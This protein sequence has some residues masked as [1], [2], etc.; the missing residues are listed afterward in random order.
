MRQAGRKNLKLE[1]IDLK[2]GRKVQRCGKIKA[3][4]EDE[5]KWRRIVMTIS[6]NHLVP[7]FT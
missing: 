1:R 7:V 4:T 3:V 2:G 6:L 5:T